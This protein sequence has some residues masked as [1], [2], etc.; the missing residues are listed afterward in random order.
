MKKIVFYRY[1]KINFTI[2]GLKTAGLYTIRTTAL[3]QSTVVYERP[4]SDLFE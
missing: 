3:I 4:V 1:I 2:Y